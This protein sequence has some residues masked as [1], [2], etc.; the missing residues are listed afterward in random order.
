MNAHF[1]AT[2]I[3]LSG[4]QA[5]ARQIER[6][7]LLPFTFLSALVHM[8][9]SAPDAYHFLTVAQDQHRCV[10][11]AIARR[12]SGRAEAIM[13]EHAQLAHRNLERAFGSQPMLELVPGSALIRRRAFS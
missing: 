6:V 12:E 5:L 7:A 4:S 3:E 10:V 9:S 8:Q 2:L 1:H 13:R 11:D